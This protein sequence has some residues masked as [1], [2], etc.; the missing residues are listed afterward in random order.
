M[1]EYEGQD[2]KI[3]VTED[4]FCENIDDYL[5]KATEEQYTVIVTDVHGQGIVLMSARKYEEHEL[6]RKLL[7]AEKSVAEHG[8]ISLEELEKELGIRE[9]D[10]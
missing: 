7:E 4:D 3:Y 10:K 6:L 8:T 5:D 9:E 2:K 1:C